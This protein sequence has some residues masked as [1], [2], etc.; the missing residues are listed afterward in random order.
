MSLFVA[1]LL[2]QRSAFYSERVYS[3]SLC[4]TGPVNEA[5]PKQIECADVIFPAC[6]V[7]L[8]LST[9]NSDGPSENER[10]RAGGPW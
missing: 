1:L 8:Q 7:Y 6:F 4:M 9:S 5:G 3:R 2:V 10:I